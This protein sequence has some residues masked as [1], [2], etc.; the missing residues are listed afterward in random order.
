[1]RVPTISA[2]FEFSVVTPF[3]IG[4]FSVGGE[5]FRW[6]LKPAFAKPKGHMIS[7]PL[8]FSKYIQSDNLVIGSHVATSCSSFLRC[9][10]SSLECRI[11]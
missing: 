11:Q 10:Q 7:W 5:K 3:A 8:K 4:P 1:M 2:V 6:I 9:L